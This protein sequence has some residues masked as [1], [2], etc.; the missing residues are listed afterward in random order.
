MEHKN[1]T[2]REMMNAILRSSGASQNLQ[3]EAILTNNYILNEL[4]HKMLEMTSYELWKS[5]IHFYK[6]LIVWG[7]LAKMTIPDP[8]KIKIG[9]RTVNYV[10]IIYSYNNIAY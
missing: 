4:P 1:Q 2:L 8:R 10:F 3:G 7:C 5:R 6:Y 9:P